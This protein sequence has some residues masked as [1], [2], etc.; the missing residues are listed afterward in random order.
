M[1]QQVFNLPKI[2]ADDVLRDGFGLIGREL[3]NGRVENHRF[4][5]AVSLDLR[6]AVHREQHIGNLRL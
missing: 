6:R 3:V 5:L 1:A 2:V 4:K